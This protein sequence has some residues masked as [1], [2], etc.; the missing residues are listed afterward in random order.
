MSLF[1]SVIAVAFQKKICAEMH[2]NDIFFIFEKLFLRSVHQNDPK[3]KK[4]NLKKMI[5]NTF[6][7]ILSHQRN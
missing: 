7:N 2:Q 1:G 3:H 5:C 6:T 4:I